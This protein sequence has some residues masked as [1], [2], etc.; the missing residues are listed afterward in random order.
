MSIQ[1]LFPMLLAATAGAAAAQTGGSDTLSGTTNSLHTPDEIAPAVLP[2]LG[3]LYATRGLPLL[4]GSDGQQIGGGVRGG[5]CGA[6][7]RKAEADALQLMDGKP[8]PNGGTA[9]SYIEAALAA[10]DNYVASVPTANSKGRAGDLPLV[11]G[12]P[13]TIEDEVKPAYNKYN[14]CLGAA[15]GATPITPANVSQKFKAA[16]ASC[17]AVRADAINDAEQALAGKGWNLAKRRA[18]AENSFAQAD[19]SWM[20]MGRRLHD[21]LIKRDA[22]HNPKAPVKRRK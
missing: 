18:V 13:V 3:C 14:E 8:V 15:A 1:L 4:R 2:Y 11:S 5:D 21:A 16:L 9:K 10:M 19:Q 7:R 6:A 20:T 17:A 22:A 12:S